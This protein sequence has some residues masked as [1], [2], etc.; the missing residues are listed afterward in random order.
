MHLFVRSLQY[1]K[2]ALD[3][4]PEKIEAYSDGG[5]TKHILVIETKHPDPWT[6]KKRRDEVDAIARRMNP[7]YKPKELGFINKVMQKLCLFFYRSNSYEFEAAE[8]YSKL[9]PEAEDIKERNAKRMLLDPETRMRGFRAGGLDHNKFD[10]T[11]SKAKDAIMSFELFDRLLF[12]NFVEPSYTEF[13]RR[14]IRYMIAS[15]WHVTNRDVYWGKQLLLWYEGVS[16][17]PEEPIETF[18]YDKWQMSEHE[19]FRRMRLILSQFRK[20]GWN[21]P[22]TEFEEFET[23]KIS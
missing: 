8:V 4:L 9:P 11:E 6:E 1:Y 16:Y 10:P 14:G 2:D 5:Y 13:F 12:Y 15:P 22:P 18:P 20:L 19:I 7:Y 3:F 23:C 21:N 17:F